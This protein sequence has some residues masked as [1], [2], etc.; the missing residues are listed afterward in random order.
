MNVQIKEK[1]IGLDAHVLPSLKEKKVDDL[2]ERLV[3]NEL[4]EQERYDL[5]NYLDST[6]DGWRNCA[7]SFLEAQSFHS[8]LKKAYGKK[9]EVPFKLYPLFPSKAYWLPCVSI[10]IVVLFCVCLFLD[11]TPTF[12][13]WNNKSKHLAVESEDLPYIQSGLNC[14]NSGR[15]NI[16][17]SSQLGG[18]NK[19]LSPKS[20]YSTQISLR[21]SQAVC[22]KQDSRIKTIEEKMEVVGSILTSLEEASK[23]TAVEHDMAVVYQNTIE[24]SNLAPHRLNQRRIGT[25]IRTVTLNCPQHG[26][27]N[28]S[29]SC[30]ERSSYSLEKFRNANKEIPQDVQE[31]VKQLR[32][33][34]GRVD[35][36]RD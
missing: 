24:N 33:D 5:L 12:N 20:T 28:V 8:S 26:L 36:H 35:I 34:G 32:R 13:T 7:L 16:R 17:L 14:K 31:I 6:Q 19:K 15:K 2:I 1:S 11:N 23:K 4:G 3:D 25:P 22:K 10:V 29:A 21:N 30:V 18:G 27:I 9:S